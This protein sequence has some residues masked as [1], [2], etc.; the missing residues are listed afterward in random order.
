[1]QNINPEGKKLLNNNNL[2][3]TILTFSPAKK[4]AAYMM[5]LKR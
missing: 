5:R 3:R 1:M 4:C 2:T